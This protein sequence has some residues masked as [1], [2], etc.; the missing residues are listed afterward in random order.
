MDTAEILTRLNAMPLV[1]DPG[2]RYPGLL[3][4][5]DTLFTLLEGL[6]QEAPKSYAQKMVRDW[7]SIYEHMMAEVGI[8]LPYFR[9]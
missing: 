3:I 5:G 2:R 1:Q 9:G 4:Q 7:I 8:E 6:E